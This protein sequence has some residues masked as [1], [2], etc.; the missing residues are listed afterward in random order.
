M[1]SCDHFTTSHLPKW[2]IP[3]DFNFHNKGHDWHPNGLNH[4]LC[5][6]LH[7]S[8]IPDI[9][10]KSHTVLALFATI[11]RKIQLETL[12]TLVNNTKCVLLCA[13]GGY[14][15]TKTLCLC[16][17]TKLGLHENHAAAVVFESSQSVKSPL[18]SRKNTFVLI[19]IEIKL[20]GIHALIF[21]V[22]QMI[23]T[24]AKMETLMISLEVV[25]YYVIK[26]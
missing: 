11:W 24:C 18:I 13:G 26:K 2:S 14:F 3:F 1:E 5:K 20:F 15:T 12:A 10:T 17:N 8:V 21:V 19:V 16:S 22:C 25:F 7:S 9:Q 6:R 23:H 4:W